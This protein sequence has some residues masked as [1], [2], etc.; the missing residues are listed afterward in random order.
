VDNFRFAQEAR[1]VLSEQRT[2]LRGVPE[3]LGRRP[4]DH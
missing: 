1:F 2:F 4:L 3:M